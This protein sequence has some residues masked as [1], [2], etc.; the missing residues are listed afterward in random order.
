[1]ANPLKHLYKA[2][3]KQY[4]KDK[5]EKREIENVKKEK[6]HYKNFLRDMEQKKNAE[7]IYFKNV[8]RKALFVQ[9]LE[10]H[11][12]ILCKTVYIKQV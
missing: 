1:M 5:K 12:R 4:N 3:Q 7:S 8:S 11:M 9:D 6:S 10:A 2:F